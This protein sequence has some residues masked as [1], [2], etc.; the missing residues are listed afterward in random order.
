MA[1]HK[2]NDKYILT[3]DNEE[4]YYNLDY[5]LHETYV[6]NESGEYMTIEANEFGVYEDFLYSYDKK[7]KKYIVYDQTFAEKY[8]IDLSGYDLDGNPVLSYIN[9][10]TLVITMGSTLYFDALNGD[11]LES[12]K[13][14]TLVDD[15]IEFKYSSSNNS[16]SLKVDG[17]VIS[18]Y[19]YDEESQNNF[20][21]KVKDGMYY[22]V[23]D[24]TF[25]MVRKSE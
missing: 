23:G 8:T 6:I 18:T 21:I 12:V 4:L 2:Y 19:D 24:N 20:Y 17:K 3:I 15:K 16:V 5:K 14:A 11:E 25:I 22:Y 13:D 1:A 10:N 9:G 7:N